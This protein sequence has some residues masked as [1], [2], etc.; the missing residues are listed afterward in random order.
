MKTISVVSVEEDSS[1]SQ[2]IKFSMNDRVPTKVL[3]RPYLT[4]DIRRGSKPYPSFIAKDIL[5]SLVS[6]QQSLTSR[7]Q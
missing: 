7:T 4:A 3:T 6:A 1:V 5:S 2:D